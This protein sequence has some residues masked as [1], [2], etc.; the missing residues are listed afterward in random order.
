MGTEGGKGEALQYLFS[1]A[2]VWRQQGEA[3]KGQLSAVGSSVLLLLSHRAYGGP[4]VESVLS[5][6]G[7]TMSAHDIVAS[8][9][10]TE[11]T[12]KAACNPDFSIP[13]PPAGSG[14]GSSGSQDSP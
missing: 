8:K 10:P 2:Q 14:T 4:T 6:Y 3:A 13:K 12:V 7:K 5:D 1:A 11:T 9:Y